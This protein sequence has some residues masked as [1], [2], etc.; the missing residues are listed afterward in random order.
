MG[1]HYDY[2]IAKSVLSEADWNRLGCV[3]LSSTDSIQ[4]CY[5]YCLDNTLHNAEAD[6][7]ANIHNIS[8]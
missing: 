7:I 8:S 4:V 3:L 1:F 2:K 6:Y 5:R